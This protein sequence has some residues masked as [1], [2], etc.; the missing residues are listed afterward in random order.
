MAT[1]TVQTYKVRIKFDESFKKLQGMQ[2]KM[3][4]FNTMQQRAAKQRI[5]QVK[6]ANTLLAEQ[7]RKEEKV[8]QAV[9]KQQKIISDA[10]I[11][12][13]V[14]GM[15]SGTGQRAANTLLADQLRKEDKIAAAKEK[16]VRALETT[17]FWQKQDADAAHRSAKATIQKRIAEAKTA[18]EV[19]KIVALEKQKLLLDRKQT[20]E[21]Q[22]QSFF[23]SK[24]TT[25]SKQLAGN[26]LGAFAIAAGGRAI[27]G[28][29]QDME[30]AAIAMDAATGSAAEGAIQMKFVRKEAERLGLDI[31]QVSKDYAKLFAAGEG[32]LPAEEIQNIFLGVAEAATVMGLS[33]DDAAGSIRAIQQMM[34]KGK[35]TAEELRLQLGDRMSPA[36]KLMAKAVGVPTEELDKLMEQGQLFSDKYLPKFGKNL[37][38]FAA[39]GLQKAMESNRMSMNKMFNSFRFAASDFFQ[40]GS[41]GLKEFFNSV[42][43]FITDNKGLWKALGATFGAAMRIISGGIKALNF[44]FKQLS[45]IL[46]PIV[47]MF[48]E[49]TAILA[50]PFIWKYVKFVRSLTTAL[51]GATAAATGLNTSLKGVDLRLSSIAKK[52][53]WLGAIVGV[54]TAFVESA[55][56]MEGAMEKGAVDA[57]KKRLGLPST[58]ADYK[59]TQPQVTATFNVDGE[60]MAKA[61]AKSSTMENRI[62]D[63]IHMAT[64]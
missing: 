25:S 61:V 36:F 34:A 13:Q 22:K 43:Q 64:S 50:L 16:A 42:K 6:A 35:I 46:E 49:F 54:I 58:G 28:I 40:E 26:M 39:P 60:T 24:M 32:K 44:V 7:L 33:Q 17:A 47:D 11:K 62:D 14:R 37:R 52:F 8:A 19:R 48:G 53:A 9:A 3:Q 31:V 2:A 51:W 1:E 63:R 30:A 29:G 4:K 21:A 41:E 12:G 5:T 15:T 38:E 57:T 18:H 59:L 23:M 20:K 55:R 45:Y 56:F 10:R 27:V